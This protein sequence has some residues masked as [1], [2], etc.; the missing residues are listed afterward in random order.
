VVRSLL[1]N[2]GLHDQIMK[3]IWFPRSSVG[4]YGISSPVIYL[5]SMAGTPEGI[6]LLYPIAL[7]E[8]LMT[9]YFIFLLLCT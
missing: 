3:K 2:A 8:R 9:F 7:P 6:A 4:T 1:P 5:I